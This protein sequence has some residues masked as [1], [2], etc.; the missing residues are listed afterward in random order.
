MTIPVAMLLIVAVHGSESR[1]RGALPR[2]LN[3]R[4]AG[5]DGMHDHSEALRLA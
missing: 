4:G 1:R 5:Q 2:L 3:V